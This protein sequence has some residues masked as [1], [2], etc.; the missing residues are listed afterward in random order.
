MAEDDEYLT[1]GYPTPEEAARA[2]FSSVPSRFV[3]V[4]RV[5]YSANG[6]TAVVELLTNEDPTTRTYEVGC[7]RDSEGLWHEDW[8]NG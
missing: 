1:P 7:E 5:A 2:G 4:G 3:R 8:G 6:A